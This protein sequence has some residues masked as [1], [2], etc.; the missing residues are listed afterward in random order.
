M[1]FEKKRKN[2]DSQFSLYYFSLLYVLCSSFDS[3]NDQTISFSGDRRDRSH[4]YRSK[5]KDG[6][7]GVKGKYVPSF[8]G[9]G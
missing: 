7:T 2:E 1:T 8:L 3:A 6:S 5:Y 9:N 4:E